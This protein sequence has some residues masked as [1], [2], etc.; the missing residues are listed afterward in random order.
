MDVLNSIG[1]VNFWGVTPY[2]NLFETEDE[3]I[4]NVSV[5]DPVN[6]LISNSNNLKIHKK[7]DKYYDMYLFQNYNCEIC[8]ATFPKYLIIKNKKVNLLDIEIPIIYVILYLQ[9]IN[10]LFLKKKKAQTIVQLI[11]IFMKII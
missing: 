3:L 8:L 6:V 5:K 11:S 2:I 4:K 9:F 1:F 10:Y 7:H